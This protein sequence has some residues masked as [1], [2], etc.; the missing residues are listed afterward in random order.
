[1]TKDGSDLKILAAAAGIVLLAATLALGV[2]GCAALQGAIGPIDGQNPVVI[3]AADAI[4]YGVGL[5][6]AKNPRARA[7]I[8]EHYGRIEAGDLTPAVVNAV[9]EA[10]GA[11]GEEYRFL[12]HKIVRLLQAL[13][14]RVDGVGRVLELAAVP[15]EIIRAG[16]DGYLAG[17]ADGKPRRKEVPTMPAQ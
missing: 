14:A 1:M 13:G 5:M 3:E 16:K 10:I 9:L 12:A 7:R 17:L 2:Q 15:P 8:E 11:D 4:G 6:A